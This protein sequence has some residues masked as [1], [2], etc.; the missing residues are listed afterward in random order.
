LQAVRE[1]RPNDVVQTCVKSQGG[2]Y[3]M[4][5]FY[6][7][8]IGSML[9]R[10]ATLFPERPAIEYNGRIWTYSEL[11]AISDRV[12]RGL[13]AIGIKKG[14]NIGIWAND[15]PNTLFCFYGAVKIGAI[16]A[17]LNTSMLPGEIEKL[18]V[19]ADVR[20]LFFD[21]GCRDIDFVGACRDFK[22]L[23]LK[24]GIY[25][26]DVH[27]EGY[28][29]SISDLQPKGIFSLDDLIECGD[30]V[31]EK[32]LHAAKSDVQDTDS[33]V[34]LF[35]SGTFGTPK[36]VVTTHFSRVNNSVAQAEAIEATENDKILIATPMFH[37]FSLSGNILAAMLVGACVY[38][39]K[40]RRTR[41]LLD[42]IESDRCTVFSAV[43][44]LYSAIIARK[45]ID[46]YDLKSLRIGLIGGSMYS[47]GLFLEIRE[48]L[49]FNLLPSLGQTE[50]TAGITAAM[51]HDSEEE[52]SS[53]VGRF[54]DHIEAEI[55]DPITNTALPDGSPG[56]LCIRGYSVM[57]GYY[58]R[59]D[60]TK[61]VIDSEGWLHT[62]DTGYINAAGNLVLTGRLKELI[63]RGGENIAPAE[64]ENVIS[65]DSRVSEVKVIGVPDPH[66]IEEICA[67]VVHN[68]GQIITD[69]DIRQL[70][71]ETLAYYKVPRYVLF[72]D[73]L[74]HTPSGKIA[75]GILKEA[76]QGRLG[77]AR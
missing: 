1:K 55:R 7:E 26:G 46:R 68:N 74:P 14:E 3:Y 27:S 33:D 23:Q 6:G 31:E 61:T 52:L 77:K 17:M 44:T 12:A 13:I 50:A 8:T 37:C 36:G 72:F 64:I 57:Q 39:P 32:D 35:T 66:Y 25:I 28:M 24:K 19:D 62:G 56:E 53:T 41:T 34:I 40:N 21:E 9:H 2:Y 65:S 22:I 75:L 16:P 38:F 30:A 45:D 42:A 69:E 58:N 11:D 4:E 29:H 47:P 67:C 15:R 43:P 76:V 63:I 10:T 59:P 18:A 60:L 73:E 20:Y 54:F 51:T 49:R 70:V 5:L 71:R 48:K